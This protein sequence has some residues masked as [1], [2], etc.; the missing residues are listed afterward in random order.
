MGA[1]ARRNVHGGG[2]LRISSGEIQMH[3][4][5]FECYGQCDANRQVTGCVIIKIIR[6][7]IGASGNLAQNRTCLFSCVGNK[8]DAG[9]RNLVCSVLGY[10][11]FE[12]TTTGSKSCQHGTDITHIGFRRAAVCFQKQAHF[13]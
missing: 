12:A 6:K 2:H 8:I 1:S 7:R 3:F 9:C 10:R 5:V 11:L 13:G 4:S